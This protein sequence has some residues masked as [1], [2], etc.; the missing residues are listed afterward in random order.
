[1]SFFPVEQTDCSWS[2]SYSGCVI[3]I[4]GT[5]K[6]VIASMALSSAVGGTAG[7]LVVCAVGRDV[8]GSGLRGL[9]VLDSLGYGLENSHE[10][11]LS[12]CWLGEG[13]FNGGGQT[14]AFGAG[15]FG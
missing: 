11:R 5:G 6:R 2:S 1:M 10:V 15:V 14:L 7:S 9:S 12:L 8:A 3:A 4:G 13:E